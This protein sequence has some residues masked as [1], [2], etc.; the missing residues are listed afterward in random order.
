MLL[1]FII[2]PNR[3]TTL[4]NVALKK[5]VEYAPIFEKHRYMLDGLSELDQLACF[6]LVLMWRIENKPELK[7]I[8]GI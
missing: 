1:S 3:I 8:L 6:D 7:S 4:N 5:I 2:E